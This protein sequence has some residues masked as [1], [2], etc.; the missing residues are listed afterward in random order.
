MSAAVGALAPLKIYSAANLVPDTAV[1]SVLRAV[2]RVSGVPWHDRGK[3]IAFASMH[4]AAALFAALRMSQELR[5]SIGITV[6][7]QAYHRCRSDVL[8]ECEHVC[9]MRTT[10]SAQSDGYTLLRLLHFKTSSASCHVI[11]G[12]QRDTKRH[13]RYPI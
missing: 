5:M 9:A 4:T 7:L 1:C 10:R 6:Y 3:H 2:G 12:L 11:A 8:C 13:L